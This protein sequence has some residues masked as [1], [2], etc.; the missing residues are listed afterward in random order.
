[1]ILTHQNGQPGRCPCWKMTKLLK[2]SPVFSPKMWHSGTSIKNITS[3]YH[4]NLFFKCLWSFPG[5]RSMHGQYPV[6]RFLSCGQG[7]QPLWGPGRRW[8]KKRSRFLTTYN[9]IP[10]RSHLFPEI[11]NGWRQRP[12]HALESLRLSEIKLLQQTETKLQ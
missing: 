1:M 8:G 12:F 3:L 6:A 10:L 9:L 5:H 4:F 7:R 2:D 11:S